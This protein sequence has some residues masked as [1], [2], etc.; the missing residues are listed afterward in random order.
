MTGIVDVKNLHLVYQSGERKVHALQGLTLEVGESETV[1]IVGESG[2]GKSTLGRALL[3]LLPSRTARILQGTI[4]LDGVDVTHYTSRQWVAMRGNPVAIVFQDPLTYL[5]PVMRIDRQIGEGV[6]KHDRGTVVDAR[7]REL[8]DL[9]RLPVSVARSYP[10]ELSGGMRQRV[11]LAIALGCR[12]RLLVADEPTTALDVTT[13]ADIIK[14]LMDIQAELKLGILMISHNLA[15]VADLCDRIYV[16]YRGRAV[17]WGPSATVMAA[18]GHPYTNGL[19]LAARNVKQHDG[20]FATIPGEV[21]DLTSLELACPFVDRC[22]VAIE[23]CKVE[24]PP[25]FEVRGDT[26]HRAACW[27]VLDSEGNERGR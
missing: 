22:T 9:V 4:H 2:S 6:A 11:L 18:P 8:L 5:N 20:R 14:L 7:V 1:G 27:L 16:M 21:A 3:G 25:D 13:Q 24:S 23:R 17:E 15:V 10:H 19:M 12:P 26:T